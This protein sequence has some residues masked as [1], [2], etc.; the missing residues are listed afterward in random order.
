MTDKPIIFSAPMVRALLDARKTQTRRVLR[1]QPTPCGGKIPGAIFSNDFYWP[2]SEGYG[3]VSC[4]PHPPEKYLETHPIRFA[5]GDRLYVKEE[6]RTEERFDHLPPSGL[7]VNAR[8]HYDADCCA[9]KLAGRYRH[10]RFM[11][12]WASRLTLVVTDVRVQRVQEISSNDV[13]A[14]GVDPDHRALRSI[15]RSASDKKKRDMYH[16]AHVSQFRTLWN[17]LHGPDAWAANPWVAAISFTVHK[18]NIDAMG[19]ASDR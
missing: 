6:W 10:A 4:K 18:C 16:D 14:E 13:L 17:S 7:P 2:I 5:P 9:P 15:P 19:G 8:I 11:P 1:P 3:V 12:R